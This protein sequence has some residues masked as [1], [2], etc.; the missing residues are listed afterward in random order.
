MNDSRIFVGVGSN[1]DRPRQQ[2]DAATQQLARLDG[3]SL[4][5]RSSLYETAAWGC[6][7]QPDFINAVI[8]LRS[9]ATPIALLGRLQALEQRAGR[10][11]D[12]RWGPRVLDLDLLAVGS[13]QL[14]TAELALPH[15][16]IAQRR[17]VLLPWHELAP[18]FFIPGLGT[19]AELLAACP[20]Q[21]R[22]RP[23]LEEAPCMQPTAPAKPRQ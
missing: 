10:V 6:Q 4:V 2:V 14:E 8:E 21:G 12:K 15:P 18:Q 22:V 16:R 7:D 19:V 11:R 20:D 5:A 3:T 23:I 9:D 13:Q 1:L 17:F